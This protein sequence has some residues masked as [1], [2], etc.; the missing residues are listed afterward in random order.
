MRQLVTGEQMKAV[1]QYAIQEVGIPFLVLMER[2]ALSVVEEM[3][4][5]LFR[6]DQILIA[7]G[8][9]NNGADGAAV[10]RM[11]FL[12]GY[13]VTVVT[14]GREE[15]RTEELK[16]QLSIN[17]KLGLSAMEAEDFIPGTC[18][19][20]VDALFGVGLSRNVE[21]AYRDMIETI[22]DMKPRLTVAVDIPSGIH[23][24]T[25]KVMGTAVKAD[26]TVT[27]GFKKVG[28]SLFPGRE[29]SGRVVVKDIGFP[30]CPAERLTGRRYVTCGPE[31]L[32]LLPGR[33][34]WSNKGTY[35]HVLIAAGSPGMAGAAYLSALAAYRMGAGLV[36]I[37]TPAENREIL[38]TLI[39]EAVL[40]VYDCAE[41]LEEPEQFLGK[42]EK[43]C[44]W[45]DAV[46]LGPG[47]GKEPW[48][49]RLVQQVLLSA[50]VPIVLDA[51]GLNI[52][53]E[54]PSLSEYFTENVLVT[55]HVGEMARLS[56]LE[57]EEIQADLTKAAEDYSEK[58]GVI[59]VLKDAATVVVR[60]DEPIYIN[61]SGCAAMAKAG[62]GDVLTGVLAALIAMGMEEGQAAVLGVY[63]HGLAG[64]A[65]EKALGENGV[66]ARDLADSL[67]DVEREEA[68][69][70]RK[71]RT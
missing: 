12:R 5:E 54:N 10:G 13:H 3:E 41:A 53:A 68:V 33:K 58:Y 4:P 57:I 69:C 37:L 50:F 46:V 71:K 22:E 23:S 45:A 15:S 7:C 32:E 16:L 52:V 49:V 28:L 2:A 26:L 44:G 65:A 64:E 35:G 67:A 61:S 38:Q 36:K 24:D 27:F 48:A 47:L 40:S 70:G 66:L 56:G 8:T 43:E 20:A 25:G 18:Q 39:P 55:P 34:P 31:D 42:I 63:L 62:S 6:E 9:G 21:G 19:A 59:T 17:E 11:L 14:V 29:Y 51:D 60:K 1:D 30:P